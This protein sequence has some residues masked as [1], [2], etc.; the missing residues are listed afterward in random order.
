MKRLSMPS[1][2]VQ[3]F[4]GV[5]LVGILGAVL[6]PALSR[7]RD[8]ARRASC[9]NNLK[10]MGIIFKMY[11][12]ENKGETYPPLSPYR[13]NWMVDATVLFPEYMTDPNVLIC[14]SSPFV[15]AGAFTA[16]GSGSGIQPE[17]V[18]S[19]FYIY[20]GYMMCSDEEAVA[21]FDATAMH[22]PSGDM[23]S[24]ELVVPDFP[25]SGRRPC[26]AQSDIPILWDRVPLRPNEFAHVPLG[27]NVLHMDGHVEFVNYSHYNNSSYFPATRISAETFGSVPPH[28]PGHCYGSW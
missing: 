18:S 15:H 20:T 2:L 21:L 19:L 4:V 12:N 11:A 8:A 25:N 5:S 17:C 22:W 23:S 27:I 6:L 10:Q 7:S 1:F 24:L 28:M 16:G 9:Q 3:F 26:G 13:D 14:P